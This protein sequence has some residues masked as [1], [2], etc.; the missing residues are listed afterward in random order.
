MF[1]VVCQRDREKDIQAEPD[2]SFLEQLGGTVV[3]YTELRDVG[4]SDENTSSAPFKSSDLLSLLVGFPLF[5]SLLPLLLLYSQLTTR[6]F[7][8]SGFPTSNSKCLVEL[9][10]SRNRIPSFSSRNRPPHIPPPSSLSLS[11]LELMS[12]SFSS[13]FVPSLEQKQEVTFERERGQFRSF[14]KLLP[15]TSFTNPSR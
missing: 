11:L 2:S 10:F 4:R 6:R 3:Q 14:T 8:G 9:S 15:R 1:V 12:V 13:P 5:L 7:V